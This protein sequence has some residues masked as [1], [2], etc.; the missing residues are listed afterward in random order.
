M[1]TRYSHV[2]D[3][4]HVDVSLTPFV[5]ESLRSGYYNFSFSFHLSVLELCRD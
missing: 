4:S 3:S 5:D 1:K 2:Q